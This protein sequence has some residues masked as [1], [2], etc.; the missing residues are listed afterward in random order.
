MNVKQLI[1]AGV[2]PL[3]AHNALV[4][5]LN[6]I[7][8]H[9]IH[10]KN[11]K[12]GVRAVTA[13]PAGFVDD[14]VWSGLA[15]CLVDEPIDTSGRDINLEPIDYSSWGSMIDSKS[16]EQMRNACRLPMARAAALMPDAHVGYG[17]PIGGVLGLENAVI[18]YGV[19]VD[20]ACRMKLS[21]ID[22]S[23]DQ[24]D[25]RQPDF[26]NALQR[27]TVFGVG[28][29]Y[30]KRLDHAVMDE[31]WTVCRVTRD[32]KDKAWT[33]LGTSGS[34]NHFV[35]WG[36][37]SIADPDNALGLAPGEY[38]ALMSHSGSRGTGAAVCNHY[39]RLARQML[40]RQYEFIGDLA[41]LD[42]DSEPGQE[43]WAAMNLMGDYAAANHALIHKNVTNH[44][45]AKIIA[46][47]ENH[48]NFAWKEVH[49]GH[50]LIVHRKGA[51]PAGEG[52]LGV[53]PGSMGT[54]AFVVSGKAN[55]ASLASASHGAGRVMSRTAAKQQFSFAAARRELAERGIKI[56]SAGADEV[57]GV[58]K[59]IEKVMAEQ[60]DLV[61]IVARFDPKIVKMSDDGKAE[62]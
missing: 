3:Y 41:W 52:V 42:L 9:G 28:G 62:D 14:P 21:V 6:A 20:I 18:P 27:G 15:R 49:D 43:Y 4:Q 56:L 13:D 44:L 53:I 29:R 5:V 57:P 51:T 24:L 30:Q 55:P 40:P 8:E 16:R 12:E 46:G 38:V 50:E 34:G 32:N 35:E 36:T 39:S 11:V 59:D 33:Q 31:D 25:R 47:V 45:G 1:S 10:G 7:R 61:H 2:P 37:L 23:V 48:H 58:Y 22:W 60:A 19:G 54:P 17:L 26:E